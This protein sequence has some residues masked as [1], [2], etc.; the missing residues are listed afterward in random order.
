MVGACLDTGNNTKNEAGKETEAAA[1]KKRFGNDTQAVKKPS[2]ND[3]HVEAPNNV[4][5][6][7]VSVLAIADVRSRASMD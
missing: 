4:M 3:T 5:A 7:M 2:G 6:I 1:V